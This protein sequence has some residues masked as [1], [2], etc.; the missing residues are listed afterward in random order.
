MMRH[1]LLSAA[2]GLAVA[3]GSATSFAG[4]TTPAS[5]AAPQQAAEPS[6]KTFTLHGVKWHHDLQAALAKAG[7]KPEAKAPLVF[8]MRVLG[9]AEGDT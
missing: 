5:P 6:T 3:L 8:W 2:C 4:E 1:V 9:D 7:K